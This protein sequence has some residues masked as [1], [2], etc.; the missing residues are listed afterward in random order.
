MSKRYKGAIISATPPTT[1]TTSASGE[2]TLTQQMQAQAAGTWPLSPSP[3]IEDLFS[4]YVYTGTSAVRSIN[5]GINLSAKGGLVWTKNRTNATDH[6]LVDTARGM[7]T[8]NCAI[9][10]SNQTNAENTSPDAISAESTGYGIGSNTLGL[11]WN[12][13]GNNY[14]SWTFAKQAKFF[15][16][17]TYSGTGGTQNVAHSLGAVPGCM[18]VK[19]INDVSNWAVYHQSL[20]ATKRMY[21]NDTTAAVTSSAF[22][23]DTTPT[24][25]VFTVGSGLNAIGSNYV[26][27][28][29]ANNAGGFGV[30]G[31]ENAIT[32]GTYTGNGTTQEINLGYEVQFLL[33]KMTNN[34]GA[35]SAIQQSWRMVDIM[36]GMPVAN[37]DALLLANT[38]DAE[39]SSIDSYCYSPTATGF[40]VLSQANQSGKTFIYIA[41]R[42][43]PMKTPTD[44][45]TVFAAQNNRNGPGSAT[46]PSFVSNFPIDMFMR[47]YKPGASASFQWLDDR[48][49][50]AYLVTSATDA[51]AAIGWKFDCQTG[52]YFPSL[53][54]STS[55]VGWMFKRA[56]GFFD[57]VCWTGTA[58][59]TSLINH[60]LGTKPLLVILKSRSVGGVGYNWPAITDTSVSSS[61]TLFLN[62]SSS[63]A[64]GNSS[65][66]FTSTTIDVGSTTGLASL[67]ANNQG[68]N[69]SG[70][71][72]VGYLFATCAGVSKVGSYTGT[73]ALQ[74]INCGFTTGA[75]FVLIKRTDSTGD[76][77]VWDSARG[78]SSSTD[79][80]LLL[81]S[82]AAE[83]TGTNYVDT[84]S[85]GFQVTAA[86]STTVNIS[87]ATYIFLAIA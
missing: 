39:N 48:L 76:W 43:G 10:F 71:T 42:R 46:A 74:T 7:T 16:I 28:L 84:T 13:S 69:A 52:V 83:V 73:A 32:C 75:R 27:Y 38:T 45:T 22:W 66:M 86:A 12:L 62:T 53:A 34:T 54:S 35:E 40:T 19:R 77:Y 57:E 31:S 17:V 44:A 3:Y 59:G 60:N 5:N 82:T 72:Y 30:T 36:R 29:F 41:I 2:W 81:N 14:V 18:F 8:A 24:S 56:P 64:G 68:G 21:L 47:G 79:P 61:S 87:A 80:Y 63:N 15:D 50:Q 25:T 49:R 58:S 78:I 11:G 55:E 33:T 26:A 51:E 20:T 67:Y 70:V 85:V 9:L 23:N 1:S 65:G 4:P 37:D 6:F